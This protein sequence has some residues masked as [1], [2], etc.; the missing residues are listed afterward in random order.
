MS[1]QPKLKDNP[2]LTI[3]GAATVNEAYLLKDKIYDSC[4]VEEGKNI[5][6]INSGCIDRYCSLWGNKAVRYI[7]KSYNNPVIKLQDIK[8]INET[9][10]NQAVSNKIIVANMTKDIE[11]FFDNGNYMAG[12]STD[13]IISSDLELLKYLTGLLNSKLLSTWYKITYNSLKMSGGAL[14]MGEII[15][16]PFY[17]PSEEQKNQISLLVQA[18]Q[19]IK[20]G[21]IHADT[22]QQEEEID[23]LVYQLYG[24]TP[25][26]VEIVKRASKEE[27]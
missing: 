18:I 21:D 26:E 1:N 22:S 11:A 20:H 10:Y 3:V 24:L 4:I 14:N 12:K 16:I 23:E 5:K 19:S 13:L 27:C 17:N 2:N 7:R 25:E 8:N 9:R 15:N 6:F